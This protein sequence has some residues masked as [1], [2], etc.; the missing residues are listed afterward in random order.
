MRVALVSSAGQCGI[1]EHS[2]QLAEHAQA[3][4]PA[5][6][7]DR[8]P[9]WLNPQA[10]PAPSPHDLVHPTVTPTCECESQGQHIV[11][12]GADNDDERRS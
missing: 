7:I 3:A 6:Q 1:A 5:L 11:D 2:A 8:N 4:D 9:A 12:D 10:Y